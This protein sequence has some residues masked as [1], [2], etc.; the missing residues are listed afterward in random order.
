M[1]RSGICIATHLSSHILNNRKSHQMRVTRLLYYDKATLVHAEGASG[2]TEGGG[3]TQPV[4]ARARENAHHRK[5]LNNH[6]THY[7]LYV[8]TLYIRNTNDFDERW[9]RN[10]ISLFDANWAHTFL[11]VVILAEIVSVSVAFVERPRFLALLSAFISISK[12]LDLKLCQRVHTKGKQRTHGASR[13]EEECHRP[14]I[15]RQQQ[16]QQKRDSN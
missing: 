2:A 16:Q 12:L 13:F 8:N 10:D 7:I 3:E 4:R 15:Q 6:I 9:A 1:Q 5:M 14:A 11:F